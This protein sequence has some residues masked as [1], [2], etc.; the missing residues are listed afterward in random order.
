MHIT[1]FRNIIVFLMR[2]M[3]LLNNRQSVSDGDVT[4]KKCT[5]S[6]TTKRIASN[7]IAPS[8]YLTVENILFGIESTFFGEADCIVQQINC[9]HGWCIRLKVEFLWNNSFVETILLKYLNTL[10][11]VVN[12]MFRCGIWFINCIVLMIKY[13]NQWW[14]TW[15][16]FWIVGANN[17]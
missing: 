14:V 5:W 2:E 8:V 10:K 15:L 13:L 1:H 7:F 6:E 17:S 4:G 9:F 3:T 12:S 16:S 11:Y